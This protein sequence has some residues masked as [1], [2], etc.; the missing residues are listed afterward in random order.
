MSHSILSV[1]ESSKVYWIPTCQIKNRF[2]PN[3]SYSHSMCWPVVLHRASTCLVPKC[4]KY[5]PTVGSTP[6]FSLLAIRVENKPLSGSRQQLVHLFIC[7]L[8]L[9]VIV[10]LSIV[11]PLYLYHFLV[12]V[13]VARSCS[14]Y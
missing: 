5:S 9:C 11:Y 1:A 8:I 7:P 14:L 6:I 12:L 4:L 3:V 13:S 10:C 2:C